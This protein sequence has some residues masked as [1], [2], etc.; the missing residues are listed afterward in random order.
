M[1]RVDSTQWPTARIVNSCNN[2]LDFIA[3]YA[4]GADRR[5]QW[6]DTNHT[7]LPIGTTNL[8]AN[9]SDYSFLADQ[10]GNAILNLTA[11][12]ILDP[13]GNYRKLQARD[14]A[15]NDEAEDELLRVAGLPTH[16]DKIADNII[17]LT[18]KPSTSV[19]AGLKFYFQRTPSYFVATD[20]TKAPGVAPL[21]HRGFVIAAA[22]DG[23]LTLGLENLQPL[24]VERDREVEKMKRYFSNRNTDERHT[25]TPT[26]VYSV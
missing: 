14:M 20:T 6:D 21:L 26:P 18:P 5:F 1:M 17:R 12:E 25:L 19:T 16:Y 11:I 7:A 22:Y 2:W 3:G 15:D 23:A 9:Q 10:Q 24:S 4:I 13:T 8:V